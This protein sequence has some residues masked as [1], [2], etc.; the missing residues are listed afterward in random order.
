MRLRQ[1]SQLLD[2][3][4]VVHDWLVHSE[5]WLYT[6]A[7]EEIKVAVVALARAASEARAEILGEAIRAV[8]V[9]YGVVHRM[10]ENAAEIDGNDE[11]VL[12][13]R[14]DL[15][16]QGLAHIG[17]AVALICEALP[18]GGSLVLPMPAVNLDPHPE[19]R[20]PPPWET[21][22][23]EDIV[24]LPNLSPRDEAWIERG[25]K[26]PFPVAGPAPLRRR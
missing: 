22:G 21:E 4:T 23:D 5:S 26:R 1:S 11:A 10:D 12:V 13:R 6:E 8:S 17:Q 20:A 9:V 3:K 15:E 7:H 25:R 19:D 18:A 16:R 24:M 14:G 2:Y